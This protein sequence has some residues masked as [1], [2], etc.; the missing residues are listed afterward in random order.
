MK[1][2]AA[3]EFALSQISRHGSAH[4]AR[5]TTALAKRGLVKPSQVNLGEWLTT[6]SGEKALRESEARDVLK[7]S[8]SEGRSGP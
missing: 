7:P 8:C 3:Q 2:T 1:L 6:P 4:S 5:S